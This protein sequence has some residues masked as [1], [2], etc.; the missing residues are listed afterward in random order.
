MGVE[1]TGLL[2]GKKKKKKKDSQAR[3]KYRINQCA[4]HLQGAVSKKG[5]REREIE[6]ERE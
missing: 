2:G 1:N 4:S 3:P 6:R 5:E